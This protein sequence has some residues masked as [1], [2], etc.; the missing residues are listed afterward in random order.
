[1]HSGYGL[2]IQMGS[3]SNILP[4]ALNNALYDRATG[5]WISGNLVISENIGAMYAVSDI[6]SFS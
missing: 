6:D 2:K 4:L 1:V 5:E 3:I